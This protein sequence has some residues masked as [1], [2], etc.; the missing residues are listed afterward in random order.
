MSKKK[1]AMLVAGALLC[2][3]LNLPAQDISLRMKDVSVKKAMTEL[4]AKSG[5]SFVYIAS[6]LDTRKT[7]SIS[8][9]NLKSAIEQI[10]AGQQVTYEIKDKTIIVRRIA[11]KTTPA[12]GKKQ[13]ITGT[14]KDANGDPVIGAS[15]KERGTLNGTISDLDGNFSLEMPEGS[16]LE[17]SYIGFATQ[18]LRPESNKPMT[19]TLNED[20]E[21]LDEVVV[22][23]YGTRTKKD[24]TTSISTLTSESVKKTVSLT[25]EMAM[26]GQMSGVQIVGNQ[27]DPNA[28]PTIRIRGINTWGVASPLFVIDGIPVKEY[29]A[30]VENDSWN[31]GQINIMSMIDPNDIESISVLK[32]A[33]SA[34]IYGL[35]ASNGVILITTKKGRR[36]RTRVEYNQR[37]AIMHQWQRVDKLMNTKQYA[38]FYRLVT[39]TNP[40]WQADQDLRDKYVFDPNSI[41]YLG[42]TQTYDWQEATLTDN[43]LT[44]DYSLRVSGGGEKNDY[45][46]SFSYANY[47]GVRVKENMERYSGSFNLHSEINKYLR[48]GVNVRLAYGKETASSAPSLIEAA[49]MPPWQPIYNPYGLYGYANAVNGYDENGIWD[50]EVLYGSMTRNNFLGMMACGYNTNSSKRMMGNAYIEIEPINNLKLKGTV[51]MDNFTNNIFSFYESARSVFTYEGGNPTSNIPEGSVGIYSER[52]IE[53][54]NLIYEFTANYLLAIKQ[55][56]FDLLFNIMGQKF[57]AKSKSGE[58]RYVS[59]TNPDLHNLSGENQYTSVGGFR[60]REALAGSLFRL[61]Y[62]YNH[63]YYLEATVRKDGSIRFAPENRW[64]IFPGISTAW[65]ISQESFLN[66]VDWVNDIK[67]RAS[68]GKLGNQEVQN[69]AYLSTISNA[70]NYAFGNDPNNPGYGYFKNGAASYGLAN[71][72]L[73]WEKTTTINMGIDFS[74]FNSLNGSIEYYHKKTD[75]ILQQVTLPLSAGVVQ[76]PSDNIGIVKNSGFEINLN[77]NK[78]IHDFYF[79]IGG[80]FTTVRNRVT[81]MYGGVPINLDKNEGVIEVGYPINYLRGYEFGGIFQ[82]KEEAIAYME[83]VNDTNYKKQFITAGDAWFKD[84]NG[85]PKN[86]GEAYSIG[87]DNI[88]NSYDRTFLGKTIPGYFYGLNLSME[89]NGLDLSAQF[90]GV[91]DIQK[92]NVVKQNFMSGW[93]PNRHSIDILDYWREDNKNTDIPR[94]DGRGSA[95]NNR[96][97]W[98]ENADYFRLANLQLGYTLPDTIYRSIHQIL[99]NARIYAGI[100]NLFTLTKYGGLDPEDDQNP[101]PIT[102][103]TGL[104]LTF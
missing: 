55:H 35:R 57:Y 16:E 95:A 54:T 53:N 71:R 96:I 13:R 14:I 8:A 98:I 103:Y 93:G 52:G 27:G 78:K 7:V 70:P 38:D 50:K 22:V 101:A 84:L 20:A 49:G 94:L 100:S 86:D 18:L 58:T 29:G 1:K 33:A 26:Q 76:Q 37:I 63:T 34:A 51:N 61:A 44:Q 3:N 80:N 73:E 25:P 10:L 66:E 24:V 62:N 75:G 32:D 42:D 17:V 60:T 97:Q 69:M 72:G 2:L 87:A 36:E 85:A 28:R 31:R 83:R 23:G 91:G 102:F 79:S 88:I 90:T 81:Q 77:Y 6:D 92:L 65:R 4:K 21:Q 56:N 46:L 68:W 19:I 11:A 47:D 5:Y 45:S 39:R 41:Q 89:Y 64:G 74:L 48:A 104:S 40:D 59:S 9:D 15:V 12:Q 30:G 82:S 43:P 99:R 67:I